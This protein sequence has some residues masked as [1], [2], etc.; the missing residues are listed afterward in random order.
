MVLLN[1]LIELRCE[2]VYF[3]VDGPRTGNTD[4]VVRV[5]KVKTL[6]AEKFA[7]ADYRVL[8]QTTN[9]GLRFG[10]PA[11]ID[12]FFSRVEA[13][14]I[15][16][17]D[18]I[19]GDSF[20]PFMAWSLER[21]RDDQQ[22]KLVSGFNRFDQANWP[23]SFRFIKVAMIWGWASWRRAWVQYDR[24]FLQWEE[25]S[26]RRRL[27][28]WVGRFE[29]YDFWKESINLVASGKAITWDVAW[30][31]TVFHEQGLVIMPRVSLVR[32]I[33]FGADS[34]NTIGGE[35]SDER[36][37]IRPRLLASPYVEPRARRPDE[38]FQYRLNRKEFWRNDDTLLGRLKRFVKSLR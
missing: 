4:D 28:R 9:S 16:E 38:E 23:E 27:R 13:G 1:R 3:A 22:V 6:I 12:W 7:P 32:N 20:F 24:L 21:F 36:F 25:R 37:A 30:C 8:Y 10:P 5:A 29:V 26:A 15:L 34:T 2:N 19:P 14:V 35:D 17:D 33:G 31:W 11:G 18:C